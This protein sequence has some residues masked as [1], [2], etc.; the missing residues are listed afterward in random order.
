MATSTG[1]AHCLQPLLHGEG[2]FPH[3]SL[4]CSSRGQS[5]LE[6]TEQESKRVTLLVNQPSLGRVNRD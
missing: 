3:L 1:R 6:V 4:D 5:S 2:M